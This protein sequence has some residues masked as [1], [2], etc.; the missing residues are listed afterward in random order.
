MVDVAMPNLQRLSISGG[1]IMVIRKVIT[2]LE[3]LGCWDLRY[4]RLE[5]HSNDDTTF[6]PDPATLQLDR[7][8]N[9]LAGMRRLAYFRL[10]L[11]HISET[12]MKLWFP[13]YTKTGTFEGRS[14][15]ELLSDRDI[16]MGV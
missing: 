5:L 2:T 9:L 7:I 10:R 1:S 16:G 8:D 12:E 15:K 3:Q 11:C 13:R 6:V 4:L 14:V